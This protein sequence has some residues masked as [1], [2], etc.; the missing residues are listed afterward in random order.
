M[1]Y[2]RIMT[3]MKFIDGPNGKIAYQYVDGS[4]LLPPIVFLCGFKSD[5]GG[6]KADWL[7]DYCIETGH[8]YL[9]FDYFGHGHSEGNFVDF[10]IGKGLMDTIF[11]IDQFITNPA[12]IIGS[13]MGG[14]IGLRLMQYL[15]QKMHGFIGIAAAPDFTRKIYAALD[16]GHLNQLDERGYI[17]EE[18]GYEEPYIFTRTL[19]DDGENHCLLGNKLFFEGSIHLLQGKLD[20]S[21]D[22]T[23]PDEINKCFDQRG[24]ITIIED[25]DHSLSRPQDLILLKKAIEE[26]SS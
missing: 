14:W 25:G 6:S 26:M 19:L 5:M 1:N 15:P 24:E 9:R 3:D 17:E 10:T 2:N 21:V 23:M 20:T 16:D 7:Y 22:W 11:V 13:S 18:S 8:P 4:S 12:I